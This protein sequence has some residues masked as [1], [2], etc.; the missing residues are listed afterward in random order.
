VASLSSD[1]QTV[2][3]PNIVDGIRIR[4]IACPVPLRSRVLLDIPG[5]GIVRGHTIDIDKHGLSV[6]IP[7]RLTAGLRCSVFFNVI[8]AGETK[9]VVGTGEIIDSTGNATDGYRARMTL[10][11]D[12]V[13]ARE[14]IE[15]LLAAPPGE[16]LQ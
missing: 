5:N 8:V 10:T 16:R 2:Q 13:D 7:A 14:A 1:T 6:T 11:I 4:K 9:V 3:L 15:Q 12:Q